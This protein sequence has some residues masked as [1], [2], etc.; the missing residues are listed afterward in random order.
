MQN[1]RSK[2]VTV[3]ELRFFMKKKKMKKKM[4]NLPVFHTWC[5]IF[6]QFFACSY[7]F[8]HVL[9]LDVLKRQIEIETE[10]KTQISLCMAIMLDNPWQSLYTQ[11][12]R[13][14]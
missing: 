6:I 4:K 1:F 13:T 8:L 9:H 12:C 5:D 11:Y 7:F 2:T 3:I 14:V 10:V